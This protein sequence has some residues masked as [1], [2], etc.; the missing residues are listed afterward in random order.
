[1]SLHTY[2]HTPHIQTGH[3]CFVILPGCHSHH[4]VCSNVHEHCRVWLTSHAKCEWLHRRQQKT[5]H[6]SELTLQPWVEQCDDTTTSADECGISNP[7]PLSVPKHLSSDKQHTNRTT[8][9]S[10]NRDAYLDKHTNSRSQRMWKGV[11][12]GYVVYETPWLS[13]LTH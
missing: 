5:L 1:M 2:I 8:A 7:F 11:N 4:S 12:Y 3:E 9:I 10:H 6:N 13:S